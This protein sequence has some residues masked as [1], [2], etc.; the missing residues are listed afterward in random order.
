MPPH[1]SLSWIRGE[2][3]GLKRQHLLRRARIMRGA[4]VWVE[5]EGR[6]LAN[7]ASNDYLNLRSDPRVLEAAR[8]AAAEQW[9]AGA[10]PLVTGR[11]AAQAALEEHIAAFEGAESALVFPSGYAANVGALT[12][13]TG[14]GDCIFSDELNHASIVDGSR[15]SRAKVRIYRHRDVDELARLLARERDCRRRLIVTDT[16]FSMDGTIAPLDALA[17][18]AERFSCVLMID[19]AHA[20]GVYGE[21]G[22]GAA[23]HLGV[24]D[25]VAVKV[26]T[27]SKALG[28]LGGFVCGSRELIAWLVNRARP[29]IYS[30]APPPAVCAAAGAAIRI[31]QEEPRR[32]R[33]LLEKAARLRQQLQQRGF[34]TG[35][36]EGPIVPVLLGDSG[37][38]IEIA[39]ELE[40]RGFLV[41]AIRPPSVPAGSARLRIGL[42]VGHEDVTID[43]LGEALAETVRSR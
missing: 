43:A 18:L 35:R 19:E 3:D 33:N 15:L 21:Q 6:R 27:L 26:G 16:V 24:S 22:R 23:E 41:G 25:R 39:A 10:S 5:V 30:T 40:Q 1:P 36:G 14:D 38:T 2:L 29:Y 4:S 11:S 17:D 12:A 20:T 32:R 34:D 7:F 28:S 37:R 9:G 8:M 42:S 13:L 31:V